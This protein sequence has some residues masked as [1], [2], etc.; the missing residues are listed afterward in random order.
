MQTFLP[1]PDFTRTA[2]VLDLRRLGKQRVE[3]LQILRALTFDDYGWRSHPAVTMWVGYTEALV[4]YG[5]VMTQRWQ[6]SGF[7]DTVLPQLLEF[8]NRQPL[9]TQDELAADDALP[10]WIGHG[11][12]HRS[13]QAALVR[14]DPEHYGPLFPEVDSELPYVWPKSQPP[15]YGDAPVSAWVVRGSGDDVAAMLTGGFVGVRPVAGEGPEAPAGVGTRNT[16]RRRQLTAFFETITPGDRVVLPEGDVLHVGTVSSGYEWR[17][18]QPNELCHARDVRWD[19]KVH[20]SEL[21]RPVHLQDPR[22]V[23]ALRNEPLLGG[24]N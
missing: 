4:T 14:K 3:A 22:I 2:A 16:K 10:P 24:A 19:A 15:V 12:L 20:R 17:G 1:Y 18:G 13:H 8:L 9:R 21:E 7:G 5:A 11:D 23:F 6:E